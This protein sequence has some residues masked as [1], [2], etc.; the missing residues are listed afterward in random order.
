MSPRVLPVVVSL[1]LGSVS[2][3]A[4]PALAAP[5]LLTGLSDSGLTATVDNYTLVNNVFAF[6]LTNT[7]PGFIMTNFGG[8]ANGLTHVQLPFVLQTDVPT[9]LV[10][11]NRWLFVQPPGPNPNFPTTPQPPDWALFIT[12]N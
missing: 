9:A 8:G 10:P 7:S 6:D 11:T 4:Q 2:I 3:C 12:Q 5:I 1:V